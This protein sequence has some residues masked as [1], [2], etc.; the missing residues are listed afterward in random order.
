M[1]WREPRRYGSLR[2]IVT[3]DDAF[4]FENGPGL[5]PEKIPSNEPISVW[6]LGNKTFRRFDVFS[7]GKTARCE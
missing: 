2:Q 1:Q 5:V 3:L 6:I 7:L 4:V